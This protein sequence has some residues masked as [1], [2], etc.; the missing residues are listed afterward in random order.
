MTI[1]HI[2]STQ[3]L[4]A[5]LGSSLAS[6]GTA[7]QCVSRRSGNDA[8][9]MSFMVDLS[10]FRVDIKREMGIECSAGNQPNKYHNDGR[11]GDID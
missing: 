4:N 10:V 7:E 8:R 6:L 5:A 2:D 9:N 11:H 3:A 1:Q